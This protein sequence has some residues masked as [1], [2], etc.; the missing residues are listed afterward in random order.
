MAKPAIK[1]RKMASM[2]GW[3]AKIKP[4]API[5]TRNGVKPYCQLWVN[6]GERENQV[7]K[8]IIAPNFKNSVGWKAQITKLN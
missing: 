7:A 6:C 3:S 5:N 4:I 2:S 8:K 1:M